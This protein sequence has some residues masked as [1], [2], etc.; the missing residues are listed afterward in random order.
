MPT[1]TS[2]LPRREFFKYTACAAAAAGLATTATGKDKKA[3]PPETIPARVLGKTRCK[4]PILGYGGAALPKKWGNPHSTEH[5]VKAV[6]Y[7][8][9]KGVRLFDM[10][11]SYMESESI[12]GEALKDVRKDIFLI[13]KVETTVPGEVRGAVEKSLKDLRTDH[14][15]AILIHG[16]PGVDRMTFK[17]AMKIHAELVKLREQRITRFV[18][19]SAHA[20]YDKALPLIA[21]GGFDLCM[22][23][24]GYLPRGDHQIYSARMTELRNACLAKAHEHRMGIIAMKVLGA[25]M[26]GAWAGHLV[27]GFDKKRL[28]RL[29]GAA[30][31][32]V[33]DDKR[34]DHL[35]IGMR[36]KDEVDANIRILAGDTAYSQND[37]ALLTEF[38]AKAYESARVKRMPV[39]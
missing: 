36:V 32:F 4:V 2:K 24:Y 5:R 23:S 1:Q 33:L 3:A 39:V 9:D 15:D 28:K 26:L 21:T 34:I 6:R 8:Y 14:V 17:Q 20:Y 10:A 18:G 30:F 11:G 35:V 16:T 29:P 13:T 22:L 12:A 19:L 27:P 31:R 38:C 7:A 25:G 37:R